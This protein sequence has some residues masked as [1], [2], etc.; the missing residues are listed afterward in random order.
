VPYLTFYLQIGENKRTDERTRTADL[1]QLRV[2]GQGLQGCAGG[3]KCRIFR[4]VSFLY[5]AACCTVLRTRWCQSGVKRSPVIR[6][7]RC[8]KSMDDASPVLLQ[9][10]CAGGDG[11]GLPATGQIHPRLLAPSAL[12]WKSS[13]SLAWSRRDSEY[14]PPPCKVRALLSLV[15]A[16]VQ[17]C[18]QNRVFVSGS[19]VSIRRPYMGSCTPGVSEAQRTPRL[20]PFY[21]FSS[22][23]RGAPQVPNPRPAD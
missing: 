1:L 2:I 14:R 3:R 6:V 12:H 15:F 11:E 21:L 13:S 18:L 9:A 17:N 20:S 4:G 7:K 23:S 22:C 19:F 10:R 5:L 8:R 16:V